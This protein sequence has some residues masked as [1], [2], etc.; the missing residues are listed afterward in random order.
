MQSRDYSFL[1]EAPEG[2]LR[3][4]KFLASKL[5]NVSRTRLQRW[6]ELGAVTVDD[7]EQESIKLSKY[8]LVAGETVQVQELPSDD[9]AA[10]KPE[11]MALEVVKQTADF[12]VLNKPA[13]LV[14]HPAPG[15]WSGT[16]MNGLLH[17]FPLLQHL[18][19]AGIV[20]R[21]DK[22]TSGLMVVAASE[23]GL[24]GLGQQLAD[25][26][27]GRKYIALV[28]GDIPESGSVGFAIGRDP[29]N[30]LRMAAFPDRS[31]DHPQV[32]A[33]LTYWRKLESLET[34]YAQ[35]SLVECKLATGRTHQIRVHLQAIG[36]PIVGDP[37]YAAQMTKV[38]AVVRSK[39]SNPVIT[40]THELLLNELGFARQALHAWSLGL[41]AIDGTASHQF[42][43]EPPS[44]FINLMQVIGLKA[45]PQVEPMANRPWEL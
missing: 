6:I 21:L 5:T 2:G 14:T 3:L 42:E 39:S 11:P 1:V 45:W 38:A 28:H 23:R 37:V 13:G 32:K 40:K 22:D 18:P 29:T 43:A 36:Y 41:K 16:L 7:G 10:F 31:N 15:H 19:R 26:S 24:L 30:R 9:S 34:P 25:R 33:A 20:H 35:F 27:M 4:D 8:K 12:I 17:H 44:D